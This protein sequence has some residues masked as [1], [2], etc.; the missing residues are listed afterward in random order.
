MVGISIVRAIAVVFLAYSI[1]IF[2][3]AAIKAYK[4]TQDAREKTAI[5]FMAI[6]IEMLLTALTLWILGI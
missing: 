6:L 4:T 3:K 5:A 2:L 1:Y